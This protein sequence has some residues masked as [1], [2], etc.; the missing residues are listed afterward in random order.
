MLAFHWRDRIPVDGRL[1]VLAV[2]S[3]YCLYWIPQSVFL[4]QFPLLYLV[5]WLGM[6]RFPRIEW[7][8]R[9]DYSYGLYL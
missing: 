8:Q 9:G 2:V 3:A 4:I 5:I 7:L 6:Q 1:A